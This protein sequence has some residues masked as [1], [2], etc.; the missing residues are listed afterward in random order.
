MDTDKLL[1]IYLNDHLAGSAA[2][3]SLARRIEQN[4][5]GPAKDVAAQLARQV[6]EDREM[7]KAL[8][9]RLG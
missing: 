5:H 7:L 9:S 4:Q 8:M 3:S 6:E 1:G 2:G